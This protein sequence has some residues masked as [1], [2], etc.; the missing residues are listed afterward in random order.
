MKV[1]SFVKEKGDTGKSTLA[2]SLAVAAKADGEWVRTIEQGRQ[3]TSAAW[4]RTWIAGG[5]DIL[6]HN[7]AG[8]RSTTL[9]HFGWA[10]PELVV[11]TPGDDGH[12]TL[13]E[14]GT[15]HLCLTAL[16]STRAGVRAPSRTFHDVGREFA[17]ERRS[18]IC[19]CQADPSR[20]GFD[21]LWRPNLSSALRGASIA[22]THMWKEPTM[23]SIPATGLFNR[24]RRCPELNDV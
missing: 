10:T 16:T 17:Y 20:V 8:E 22:G 13:G 7:H 19:R 6:D 21:D 12:A 18:S 24:I 14:I 4:H 1:V 11:S 9:Y 15:A 3:A 23:L 5:P 2:V